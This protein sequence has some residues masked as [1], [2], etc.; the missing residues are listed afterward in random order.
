MDDEAPETVESKDPEIVASAG[1]RDIRHSI[2]VGP[3][4]S[5]EHEDSET[6][7]SVDLGADS[8]SKD[9]ESK[10]S[11]NREFA[12]STTRSGRSDV[13]GNVSQLFSQDE[14][15]ISCSSLSFDISEEP[16]ERALWESSRTDSGDVEGSNN[17]GD[18]NDGTDLRF[19]DHG[20]FVMSK[21]PETAENEDSEIT[22]R[23][24]T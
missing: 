3:G 12:G 7:A 22:A 8:R 6:A 18:L 24:D 16:I 10:D 13:I 14:D 1:P 23:V 19:E 15:C 9:L 2:S 11:A 5:D 4:A 21:D 17:G 20:V